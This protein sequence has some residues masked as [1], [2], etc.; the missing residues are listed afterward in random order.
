MHSYRKC[1]RLNLSLDGTVASI[2]A[3]TSFAVK[4][5]SAEVCR[6][7]FGFVK[8]QNFAAK[9][10]RRR[11]FYVSTKYK[12]CE[13]RS[14]SEILKFR[15]FKIWRCKIYPRGTEF[16]RSNFTAQ[17][18]MA[19]NLP[20]EFSSQFKISKFQATKFYAEEFHVP[21]GT[22]YLLP[23]P[24]IKFYALKSQVIKFYIAKLHRQNFMLQNPAPRNLKAALVIKFRELNLRC[25]S[26]ICPLRR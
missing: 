23:E 22:K 2:Y 17:N 16:Y 11:I 6:V 18:F 13:A 24:C 26:D 14:N 12:I 9:I 3:A 1:S 10:P 5:L 20:L 21:I 8:F 7:K 15:N 25:R 19:Q 4:F